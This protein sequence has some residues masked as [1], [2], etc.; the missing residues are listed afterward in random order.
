MICKY[1]A[2]FVRDDS[3]YKNRPA[4]DA[5][6]INRDAKTFKGGTPCVCHPPCRTWGVLAHMAFNA[7]QGEKQLALWSVEQIRK[8]G[9]ILEHPSTSGVFKKHVPDIG[10][11]CDDW[12]GY[13][14]LID[15]WD[16]GHVAHKKTK[17]L[18]GCC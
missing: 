3:E 14:I 4:F 9:G 7:R 11:F 5:Y 17:R 15:Q 16:F 2:L 13:T 12:G 8:N 10:M 6:D 1:A 18:E